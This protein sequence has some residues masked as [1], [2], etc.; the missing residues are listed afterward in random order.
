MIAAL[1]A[2]APVNGPI[3]AVRLVRDAASPSANASAVAVPFWPWIALA[4]AALIVIIALARAAWRRNREDPAARAFRRLCSFLRLTRAEQHLLGDL[5]HPDN[6]AAPA[7]LPSPVAMLL[8]QDAFI[9][10]ASTF[11]SAH[12]A[13]AVEQAVAAL[14]RKIFESA[15]TR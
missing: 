11:K 12:R 14:H 6:S 13:T 1:L 15:G 3:E 4:L 5:A 2:A 8:S 10:A 9:R 7:A